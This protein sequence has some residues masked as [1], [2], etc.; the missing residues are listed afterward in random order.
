[1]IQ[2]KWI[3]DASTSLCGVI[4]EPIGHSL[5][6]IMQN[7]AFRASDLN[8]VYLAFEV[9]R[10]VLDVAIKGFQ[11][12][13]ILG[14]NVTIPHKVTITNLLDKIDNDAK[15]V[16]AVNTIL[17]KDGRM[18][19]FNTD[20]EGVIRPLTKRG[21]QDGDGEPIILG[22]GGA[23]RACLLALEKLGFSNVTV[24]NRTIDKARIMVEEVVKDNRLDC[25]VLELSRRNLINAVSS[26]PI[27]INA[28]SVGMFD[29]DV[30]VS[31]DVF[32]RNMVVFDVVY[33][34]VK[35]HILNI[36]EKSGATIVP[37]YEMLVSQGEASFTIWTG[38]K[39]PEGV[40]EKAVLQSLGEIR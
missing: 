15:K 9:K 40:M 21:L 10:E 29:S 39:P 8:Y 37:G 13:N 23:A 4:G 6:P 26:A 5:S 24:L 17:N 27:I 38:M 3:A 20:V 35:T 12:M 32:R 11:S 1:M 28:T 14:L 30:F 16:G 2:S 19:G 18:I 22:A 7:A 34:P 31:E 36:A 33:T 25:T